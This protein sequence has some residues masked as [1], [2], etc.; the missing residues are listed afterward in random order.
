MVDNKVIVSIILPVYNGEKYIGQAIRSVLNQ[1]FKHF[2]LIIVDDASTDNTVE[3]ICK[4]K[5]PR[6]KL[7]KLGMNKGPS[8]ARNVGLRLAKGKWVAFVDADDAWHKERLKKLLAAAEKYSHSFIG[9]DVMVCFSGENNE[10]IPWK[11]KCKERSINTYFMIFPKVLDLVK[12][13]FDVSPIFPAEILNKFNVKFNQKYRGNEWLE[14]MLHFYK[15]G[16]FLVVINDPLYYQRITK[17]SLSSSY[18]GIVNELGMS[19]YIQSLDWIDESVKL[20]LQEKRKITEYRLLT[21]ALREKRWKKALYH[22]FNT[23]KSLLYLLY[24]YPQ[25]ILQN[26][27]K[28][29]LYKKSSIK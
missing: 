21:S 5:D 28:K 24:R 27:L 26:Y 14:F 13:G 11:S 8:T 22:V 9:S 15:L 6:I 12:N 29:F 10:L 4:Y 7:E 17:G 23:P 18:K 3:M 19:K 2:E 20:V 1:T 16:F 25:Y